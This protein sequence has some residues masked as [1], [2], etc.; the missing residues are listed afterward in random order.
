MGFRFFRRIRICPGVTLNVG[1]RGVSASIGPRGARVTIGKTGTRVT[2]GIPGTGISYTETFSG[3]KQTAEKKAAPRPVHEAGAPAC[4][5]EKDWPRLKECPYCGHGFRKRWERC[6]ECHHLLDQ[7]LPAG[8]ARCPSCR[9]VFNDDLNFCPV[10]G[11]EMHPYKGGF[12]KGM[13]RELTAEEKKELEEQHLIQCGRCH[14]VV[15][16]LPAVKYCPYCGK[17]LERGM[18]C[19]GAALFLFIS[20]GIGVWMAL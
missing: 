12:Y 1:K 8:K 5:E 18:G 16:D 4:E 20:A 6:P 19:A 3:K 14:A 9:T 15:P 7:P 17:V 2:A 13:E 10:C 11:H